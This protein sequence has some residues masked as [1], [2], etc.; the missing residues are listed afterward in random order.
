[1]N[2]KPCQ[3][4]QDNR[5]LTPGEQQCGPVE[6]SDDLSDDVDC[7]GLK[8]SKLF[9][10]Q[11]RAEPLFAAGGPPDMGSNRSIWRSL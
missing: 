8:G 9:Q 6:L 5:V 7:L 4:K 3:V 10:L 1:M 2:R 11:S